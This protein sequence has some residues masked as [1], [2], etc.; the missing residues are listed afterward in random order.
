MEKNIKGFFEK[1]PQ[2]PKNKS[3]QKN[4]KFNTK[5]QNENRKNFK[6]Y[7]ERKFFHGVPQGC[8]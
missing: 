7:E 1:A 8:F 3:Q 2:T 6:K 5:Q 4:I